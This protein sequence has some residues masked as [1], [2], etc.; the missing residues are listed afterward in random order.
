MGDSRTVVRGV[1]CTL[2]AIIAPLCLLSN[3]LPAS[4]GENW[5]QF[6]GPT[7]LGYSDEKDLPVRWGGPAKENVLWKSPLHGAGHASP[8]VWGDAVFVCTV[9]WAGNGDPDESVIPDHHV[10]CYRAADGKLLW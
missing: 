2:R 1:T 10:A 5:P 3:L 8:L 9:Q 4:G 7:G 6:R